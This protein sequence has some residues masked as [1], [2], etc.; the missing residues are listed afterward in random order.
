MLNDIVRRFRYSSGAWTRSIATLQEW[1][2]ELVH[3][4]AQVLRM[5]ESQVLCRN[6]DLLGLVH[7]FH[8]TRDVIGVLCVEF[9]EA[10]EISVAID[11]ARFSWAPSSHLWTCT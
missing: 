1:R 6:Y 7:I 5:L 2:D 9:Y 8:E 4:M 3:L 11:K 10:L